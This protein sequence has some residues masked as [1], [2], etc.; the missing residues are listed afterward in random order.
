MKSTSSVGYQASEYRV[1]GV[2]RWDSIYTDGHEDI[3]ERGMN[4][5]GNLQMFNN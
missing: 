4:V 3:G 2:H 1:Y 5:N